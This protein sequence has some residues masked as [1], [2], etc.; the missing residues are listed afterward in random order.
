MIIKKPRQYQKDALAKGLP[1]PGF[2]LFLEQRTGKCLTSLMFVDKRKPDWLI[3]VT[4]K[5]GCRVWEKEIRESLKIDWECEITITYYQE[6]HRN[7]KQYRKRF[8]Q[9]G[10]EGIFIIGDESHRFKRRGAQAAR[11]IRDLGHKAQ[12]RLALTGTP[13]QP[14]S[15]SKT[16]R[17]RTTVEVTHGLEDA[18]AQFDFLDQSIFGTQD[19]FT[20]DHLVKGGFRGFQTIGYR[21]VKTFYRKLHKYSYR[22]QLREVQDKKTIIHRQKVYFALSR[23]TQRIYDELADDLTTVI[24]GRRVTIPLIAGRTTKLQQVTSGF[25]LD[26]ERHKLLSDEKR[27]ALRSLLER[28][29][30]GKHGKKVVICAKFT[31]EIKLIARLISRLGLT[32]QTIWGGSEFSGKFDV[33]VTLLQIKSGIAIDLSEADTFIFCSMNHSY[34]DYEQARFRIL[35]FDKPFANF[36]YLLARNSVDELVYEAQTKKKSLSTLVL[37]HYR[38]KHEHAS[39]TRSLPR[40]LGSA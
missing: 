39:G 8:K 2:A 40:L 6:L 16:R 5:N 28:I 32:Y 3:I 13:V 20:K 17:G 4:T 9:H 7:R 1:Y 10:P 24:R 14:R 26:G 15:R 11:I 23:N 29:D 18:W 34:F 37:E 27:L 33:D 12:W 21:N 22:R 25:V 30:A 31:L 19:Q 35:S 38:R 36:Y